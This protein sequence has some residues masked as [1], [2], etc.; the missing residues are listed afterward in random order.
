MKLQ[1]AFA[2]LAVA[3]TASAITIP[4]SRVKQRAPLRPN[5]DKRGVGILAA[6]GGVDLKNTNNKLYTS[7]VQG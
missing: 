5:L 7:T 6:A 3:S 2:I 1:A 4:V